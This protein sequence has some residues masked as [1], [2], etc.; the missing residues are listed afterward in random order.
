[1]KVCEDAIRL[2]I[3]SSYIVLKDRMSDISDIELAVWL[4]R[5]YNNAAWD[6]IEE[7]I[8]G[9]RQKYREVAYR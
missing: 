1:M 5:R 7:I 8:M 2:Y 6:D 4:A 9:V 3:E